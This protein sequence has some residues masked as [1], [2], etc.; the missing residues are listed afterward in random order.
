[1]AEIVTEG[2]RAVPERPQALGYR[3]RFEDLD[4]ALS[5]ALH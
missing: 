3:F 2:Q 5:D 1:M 4:A